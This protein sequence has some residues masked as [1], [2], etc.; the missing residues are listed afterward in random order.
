MNPLHL[1]RQFPRHLPRPAIASLAMMVLLVF[2]VWLLPTPSSK[3]NDKAANDKA[4]SDKVAANKPAST[5][6]AALTV[7]TAR[8]QLTRLSQT[9]AA[10]GDIAAWQEASIGSEANGL[11]LTEVLVN[12]GD[13]VRAGQTLARFSDETVQADLAQTNAALLKRRRHSLKQVRMLSVHD[14]W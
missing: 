4:T 7:S 11:R 13:V 3:A 5:P 1:I 9:L 14:P 10:N 12:V 8:P 2:A 6:K